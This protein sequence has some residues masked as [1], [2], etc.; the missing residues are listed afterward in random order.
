M[1]E[2]V[3]VCEHLFSIR[4]S[5]I[6]VVVRMLTRSPAHVVSVCYVVYLHAS[7]D[8]TLLHR[9]LHHRATRTLKPAVLPK[10]ATQLALM[11]L[12]N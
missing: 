7:A 6:S 8:A 1:C 2:C 12:P 5:I 3:R 11:S 4:S 9:M 10:M